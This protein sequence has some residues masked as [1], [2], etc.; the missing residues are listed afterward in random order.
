M[1]NW[2]MSLQNKSY[3]ALGVCQVL[4]GPDDHLGFYPVGVYAYGYFS[5]SKVSEE[6]FNSDDSA[7]CSDITRKTQWTYRLTTNS[8]AHL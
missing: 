3:P 8:K 4:K 5:S 6:Q 2:Y 1:Q 7:S